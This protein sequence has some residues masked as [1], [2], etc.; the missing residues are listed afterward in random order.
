MNCFPLL[1]LFT[2]LD[3][4]Q[5]SY[6]STNASAGRVAPDSCLPGTEE[7]MEVDAAQDFMQAASFAS[8][9]ST[10][11]EI[12][13]PPPAFEDATTGSFD[14]DPAGSKVQEDSLVHVDDQ[15]V[16]DRPF[17]LNESPL[18]RFVTVL[19]QLDTR[20]EKLRKE[21]VGLQEKRDFLLMS[22]DLIK[23]N[24]VL[25]GMNE[26]EREE[27]F[28]YIHR[29]NSRLSTVEL[30]VKTVR[31]KAQEES[32]HQVNVLIDSL[33]T[34]ND[35]V[36]SRQRCQSFL[37]ACSASDMYGECYSQLS[38]RMVDKNFESALLG[39]TLDDQKNIKKRLQALMNYL[40]K[41]TISD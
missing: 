34:N 17:N 25:H 19:D 7:E 9:L 32:L 1:V 38:E 14:M 39:C 18:S 35:A 36:V 26:A 16:I 12:A 11:S 5:P 31:D 24:D 33:I 6:A 23:N 37:N 13:P 21:A 15:C 30:N 4:D 20:V 2:K 8:Y 22:I 10:G 27:I 40:N 29:V 28:C 3:F 41:Q